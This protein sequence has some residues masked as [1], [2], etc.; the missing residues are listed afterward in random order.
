MMSHHC[1][2]LRAF[3]MRV[4]LGAIL[5]APS[6]VF[7]T[8]PV[9]VVRVEEDWRL[10]VA[11]PDA[12]STG[13]QVTCAFS[14]TQDTDS[15]YAAFEL[16]HQSQP[17]FTPGGLQLQ[18]WNDELAISSQKFPHQGQFSTPGEAVSW[19]QAMSVQSGLLTFEIIDGNST[20]WGNFGGQGY[21]KTTMNTN[22]LNLNGYHPAVSVQHSG[23][24][25]AANRVQE[26]VLSEVRLTLADGQVLVDQTDRFVYQT[27]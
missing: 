11:T 22:L 16:N 23:I 14:P 3:A 17:A 20:T 26:L 10:V 19:T 9:V 2:R 18:T 21:L 4:A 5:S 27:N 8:D 7:G 25:Y 15:I 13:P 24:G 1:G 6:V 12:N